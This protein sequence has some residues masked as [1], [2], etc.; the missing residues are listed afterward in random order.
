MSALEQAVAREKEW[1]AG[2]NDP[3]AVLDRMAGYRDNVR[4]AVQLGDAL[5]RMRVGDLLEI[6]EDRVV[7]LK[8]DRLE[9]ERRLRAPASHVAVSRPAEVV[10]VQR[11]RE[12][13]AVKGGSEARRDSG[14][15]V[16]RRDN[17]SRARQALDEQKAAAARLANAQAAEVEARV[18][19]LREQAKAVA[20]VPIAVV[21][22]RE[23]VVP[24][25]V[26]RALASP[27]NPSPAERPALT[28]ENRRQRAVTSGR[29]PTP[30]KRGAVERPALIDENRP[31]A[32]ARSAAPVEPARRR[33]ALS[34][35]VWGEAQI[36]SDAVN[37]GVGSEFSEADRLALAS[38]GCWPPTPMERRG[39]FWTKDADW[40][41]EW[42]LTGYDL[43]IFRG[44]INVSRTVLAAQLRVDSRVLAHAEGRPKEKVGPALQIALKRAIAVV[45][46]QARK[47]KADAAAE[48][49]IVATEA[50][51]HGGAADSPASVVAASMLAAA[52]APVAGKPAA[53]VVYT[54]RDL[55]RLRGERSLSQR[56]LAVLLGVGHGMIGKAELVPTKPLGEGMQAA[57][58]T[59]AAN[60][61][62]TR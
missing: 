14:Q 49:L 57:F 16:A 33:S 25:P 46:E 35:A 7:E 21:A 30:A 8:A 58:A 11:T 51:Q 19:L 53:S 1:I 28:G 13:A 60:G 38:V 39:A 4:R 18:A 56:E 29:M 36:P 22:R 34:E 9:A 62:A 48:Q 43:A 32:V 27:V 17:E 10:A 42:T 59:V 54:G 24:T 5:A 12:E 15:D 6:A 40:P 37:M 52:P 47:R 23:A 31:K 45:Q 26:T 2:C 3:H 50:G 61:S 55:A 41:P 44:R 20:R